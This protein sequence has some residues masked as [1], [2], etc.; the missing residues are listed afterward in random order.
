MLT[1]KYCEHLP[2]YRQRKSLP[3]RVSN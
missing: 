1:G 2:L 3:A